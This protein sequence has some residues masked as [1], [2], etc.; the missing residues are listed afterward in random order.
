MKGAV[1]CLLQIS[2][3][4]AFLLSGAISAQS[5][6]FAEEPEL[7]ASEEEPETVVCMEMDE[8]VLL[9]I[10]EELTESLLM[11]T[12]YLDF[13]SDDAEIQELGEDVKNDLS[14]SSVINKYTFPVDFDRLSHLFLVEIEME[15]TGIKQDVLKELLANHMGDTIT[16]VMQAQRGANYVALS[17]MITIS[18]SYV[19][20]LEQETLVLMEYDGEYSIA[21]DFYSTGEHVVTVE[22][23][24]IPTDT[25]EQIIGLLSQ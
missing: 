11:R 14:T 19:A 3:L 22:E 21:A 1:K 15:H 20:D 18:K 10:T 9:T 12:D 13:Y 4:T 6:V 23:T 16:S 8:K 25:V 17:A 24:L 7:A 5:V 2:V